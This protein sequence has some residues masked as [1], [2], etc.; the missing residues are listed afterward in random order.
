MYNFLRCSMVNFPKILKESLREIGK[1]CGDAGNF[2]LLVLVLR[3][4]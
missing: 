3:S 2:K 1:N 4:N